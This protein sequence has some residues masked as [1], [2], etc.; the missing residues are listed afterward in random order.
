MRASEITRAGYYWWFDP[1]EQV[2]PGPQWRVVQ[3][4]S[5]KDGQMSMYYMG[6]EEWEDDLTK[7]AGE[8]HGPLSHPARRIDD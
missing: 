5:E 1:S 7:V 8:F 6:S 2:I 3:F 4:V